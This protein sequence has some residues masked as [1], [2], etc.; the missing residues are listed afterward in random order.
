MAQGIEKKWF[1]PE[2]LFSSLLGKNLS[3]GSGASSTSSKLLWGSL[4]SAGFQALG[5]CFDTNQQ[6]CHGISCGIRTKC[7]HPQ[8]KKQQK[9][10]GSLVHLV[11][12]SLM[13]LNISSCLWK[14][15]KP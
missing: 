1:R 12:F 7:H 10:W 9:A 11:F 2:P 4:L 15:T 6:R 13:H 8:D 3:D 5:W 14:A